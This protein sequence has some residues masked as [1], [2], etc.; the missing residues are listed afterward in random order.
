MAESEKESLKFVITLSGTY[1]R[2]SPK[3]TI[4]IDD[5]ILV[6]DSIRFPSSKLGLPDTTQSELDHINSLQVIEFDHAVDAGDH[7]INIRMLEKLPADTLLNEDG[8]I[9]RDRLLNIEK[10]TIDGV[11]I[12]QL[13]Y[14][15]S[16]YRFDQPHLHH[17][18]T[19]HETTNCVC[20]GYTGTWSLPFTSPFYLWLLERL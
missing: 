19:Q 3:F 6:T 7:S 5:Q 11:D 16:T 12:D 13:I 20:L 1:W 14:K 15:E 17:G 8:S 2:D 18:T 9:F 10:I 4:S